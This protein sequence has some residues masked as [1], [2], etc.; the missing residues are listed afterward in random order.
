MKKQQHEAKPL[1]VARFQAEARAVLSKRSDRQSRLLK[2]A[3]SSGRDM[4]PV[5]RMAGVSL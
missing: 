4:E 5:G 3:V 1:M 2:I